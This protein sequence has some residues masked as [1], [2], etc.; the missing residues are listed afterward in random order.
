MIEIQPHLVKASEVQVP[1][2]KSYT[3]RMLIA[4]ALSDGT[5]LIQNALMSEDTLLTMAALKQMGIRIEVLQENFRVHGQGG[6]LAPC[7]EPI[8]TANSGTTMR[9]L[10]AVAALGKGTYTLTGNDRMRKRPIKDLLDALQQMRIHARR[11]RSPAQRFRPTRW[12]LT[13]KK[14]ASTF[15]RC[16]SS[17]PAP[18]M[19]L[20]FALPADRYPGLMWI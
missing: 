17:G 11:S 3:H 2:S 9:L 1:G 20:P 4:A 7:K 10:T 12:I 19:G 8:Y 5:C 18:G 6:C 15:L 14:A 16:Y 13:A